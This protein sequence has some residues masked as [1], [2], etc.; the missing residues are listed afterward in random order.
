MPANCAQTSL[1]LSAQP[2]QVVDLFTLS[3]KVNEG[4]L[5]VRGKQAIV[6]QQHVMQ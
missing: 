6:Q 4:R 2:C 1:L 3:T 5:I